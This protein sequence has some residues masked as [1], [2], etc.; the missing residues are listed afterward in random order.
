MTRSFVVSPRVVAAAGVIAPGWVEVVNATVTAVGTGEPPTDLLVGTEVV[1]GPLVLPGYVDLHLHGGGGYDVT[2]SAEDVVGAFAFHRAHGTTAGLAS[3]VAAPV[4]EL[5]AQLGRIADVIEAGRA[6][7]LVGVHLEGPFLAASR[8]GALDPRYLLAPDRSV[9]RRLL[10]AG[11]GHVRV[12][13]IAPELPGALEL[14]DYLVAAGV[15]VA[16]GHTD[17]TYEQAR[18]AFDRGATL[19]T[20]LFNAMRPLHHRDPGPVGAALDAGVACELINDGVHTHPAVADLVGPDRLVLVTDAVSAAGA[21]DG[22][23]RLGSRPVRVRDGAVRLIGSG[24][25]AGSTLTMGE[26]VRRLLADSGF[27]STAIAAACAR[28]AATVLGMTARRGS[29]APG[30]DADLVVLDRAGRPARVMQA[31]IWIDPSDGIGRV[32]PDGPVPDPIVG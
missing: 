12:V 4:I 2:R 28:R 30:L 23:Y 1:R 25:L 6:P 3:L 24:G 18:V 19:V 21:P 20:H 8:C 7:G 26:A 10:A 16:V 5:C 22:E 27:G 13:T 29:I 9:L 15:V 32:G 31:G 17:A 14:L 11:R